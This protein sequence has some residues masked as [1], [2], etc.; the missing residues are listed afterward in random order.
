[1]DFQYS[2]ALTPDIE[3]GGYVV[4]CRDLPEAITQGDSIEEALEQAADCLEEA[5]AG[6]IDDKRDIP[7]PSGAEPGEYWVAVPIQTA[8]KATL[9]LAMR[10]TNVGLD[11]LA[12]RLGMVEET[13]GALLDP[14]CG[15]ETWIL[16]KA[17][18][19]VGKRV[20]LE[21]FEAA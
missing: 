4:T 14:A 15:C 11:E 20:A 3:D 8:L 1:M 13:L 5:I 18:A 12:R 16:E 9:Y 17:L 6:R 7:L 2:V 10:E 19:V 21:V